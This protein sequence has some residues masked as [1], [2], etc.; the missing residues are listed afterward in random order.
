[1]DTPVV[2][3]SYSHDN[4]SHKNWV[5]KLATRLREN[6]V[7][8][9]LDRWNISLGGDIAAFIER[10]LSKSD[11][12][13]CICTDIYVKKA[14]EGKGGA[15]YEKQIISAEYLK[16]QNTKTVIPLIRNEK[17]MVPT[18]LEGRLYI[19]FSDEKS[20][21]KN[22]EALLREILQEPS[23]PI[24]S[25]GENPF[26]NIKEFARQI[27]IPSSEKYLSPAPTGNATFDYSNNNG[28]YAIGQKEL[29][30]ELAFSKA[31]DTSIY[32]YNDPQ[33][34]DNVA[35]VKDVTEIYLINDARRYDASS[36]DRCAQTNQICVLKNKNGYYA[37]IK[38][39]DIKDDTR[40]AINDEITF[41]YVI[42]TNGSSDFTNLEMKN[43]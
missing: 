12:I 14:N 19:D 11:R 9:I 42:Q 15:G 7:N 38:I 17:S 8:T 34:I 3:I 25:I 40:G 1:M 33:S 28:R 32:I 41:D 23:L 39:L 30:F 21:E 6:G 43:E 2:F 35:L 24:P 4:E 36:R 29:L 20:F 31:S 37:A 26:K 27:F 13:L 10:G 16:N 18:F 22:Y 5:L